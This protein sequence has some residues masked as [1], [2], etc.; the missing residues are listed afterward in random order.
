MF[1]K[2]T[3]LKVTNTYVPI[4]LILFFAYYCKIPV[5]DIHWQTNNV[6]LNDDVISKNVEI[7]NDFTAQH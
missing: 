7:R 1:E 2:P 4:H 3:I 5:S 6:F